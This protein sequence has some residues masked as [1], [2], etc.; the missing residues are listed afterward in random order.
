MKDVVI[1][2]KRNGF[3]VGDIVCHGKNGH[4]YAP[5]N[6]GTIHGQVVGVSGDVASVKILGAITCRYTGAT[7][8]QNAG[9]YA[10]IVYDGANGKNRV[11]LKQAQTL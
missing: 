5:P 8:T 4:L 1:T 9:G 7:L 6:S 11:K 2:C 10:Q 3:E